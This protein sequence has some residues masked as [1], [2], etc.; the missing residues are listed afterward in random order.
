MSHDLTVYQARL[1]QSQYV[2]NSS[3]LHAV[4]WRYSHMGR[5]L[6]EKAS[7][8]NAV[9]CVIGHVVEQRLNYGPTGN[10]ITGEFG[11]L[12]KA[13]YQLQ[14]TKP[15]GTPFVKDYDVALTA[16]KVLQNQATS[17]GDRHN[18]IVVDGKSENIRSTKDVFEKRAHAIPHPSAT[19]T[20]AIIP[21]GETTVDTETENWPVPTNMREKLDA[22]KYEYCTQ[23]LLVY[24]VDDRFVEPPDVVDTIGGALVQLQFE[25]VHYHISKN[26]HDSFNRTIAQITVIQP[27]APPP[28]SSL[29]RTN[30]RSA[31]LR[32][33]PLL[34]LQQENVRQNQPVAGPSYIN[35][36][37]LCVANSSTQGNSSQSKNESSNQ[38]SE[39]ATFSSVWDDAVNEDNGTLPRNYGMQLILTK[40]EHTH[41]NEYNF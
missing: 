24:M 3:F 34:A 17:M 37:A 12:Q 36:S 13:K 23:P 38:A 33:N 35:K 41:G 4:T 1:A 27:G 32:A 39:S 29:K 28:T 2:A 8:N 21:G 19:D 6:V 16:L 40:T 31:P 15:T 25:L 10:Y 22:I 5:I 9:V 20:D 7:R 14:I 26:K 30:V 11:S 18:L